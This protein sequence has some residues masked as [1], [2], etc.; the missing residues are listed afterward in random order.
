MHFFFKDMLSNSPN[1]PSLIPS[2]DATLAL[3]TGYL[4][5]IR[6]NLRHSGYATPSRLIIIGDYSNGTTFIYNISA[7]TDNVISDGTDFELS[8]NFSSKAI[9][10]TYR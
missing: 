4:L 3:G 1:A 6:S 10:I 7:I 2:Y 8:T 5:T 9:G